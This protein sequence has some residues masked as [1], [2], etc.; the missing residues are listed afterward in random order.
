MHALV[1]HD[2]VFKYYI[3]WT[4]ISF[5]CFREDTEGNEDKEGQK[6]NEDK[7]GQKDKEDKEGQWTRGQ[8]FVAIY[9]PLGLSSGLS[10]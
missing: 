1:I 6:G 3:V 7:E 8:E 2:S 9:T 10:P 5:R 4:G